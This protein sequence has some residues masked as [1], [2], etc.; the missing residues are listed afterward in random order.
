MDIRLTPEKRLTKWMPMLDA[1]KVT[2]DVKRQFM[3]DY[4]EYASSIPNVQWEGNPDKMNEKYH[5]EGVPYN[6]LTLLNDPDV[7]QNLL[8]MSMSIISK[9]NLDGKNYEI[10]QDLQTNS[11]Y[12][13]LTD[14]KIKGWKESKNISSEEWYGWI[15]IVEKILVNRL[16]ETVNK[17]LETKDTIYIQSMAYRL[18][19]RNDGTEDTPKPVMYL[20][21]KYEI[22]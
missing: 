15:D 22:N 19:L 2:D 9:L 17:E 10:K 16:I 21:S 1:L 18:M 12:E 3:A 6:P 11:F 14:E 5:F 8:P 4:G 13:E 7:G 20:Y